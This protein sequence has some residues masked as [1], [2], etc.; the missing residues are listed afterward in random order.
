METL[1]C[2]LCSSIHLLIISVASI[3]CKAVLE[4]RVGL[5]HLF[6]DFSHKKDPQMDQGKVSWNL[7]KGQLDHD[8]Q[9]VPWHL[10]TSVNKMEVCTWY[11]QALLQH[12][13]LTTVN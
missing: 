5:K 3:P 2:C 7:V 12:L 10:A 1:T 13:K 6:K 11:W 4:A 8:R 9:L